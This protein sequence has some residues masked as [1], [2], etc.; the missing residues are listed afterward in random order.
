MS[1]ISNCVTSIR[2]RMSSLFSRSV[3]NR[4][5]PANESDVVKVYIN[6]ECIRV[7]AYVNFFI[8]CSCA[9]LINTHLVKPRLKEGPD[10][11]GSTCSPFDGVMG[12]RV[13]PPVFPGEGFDVSTQSHL[14]RAFG[15]NNI[16]VNWDYSPS[17]E[18]TAM[19]YPIFEYAL[20]LYLFFDFIQTY[21]YFKK[22]WV[23]KYYFRAVQC[24]IGFMILG[25]AWFR[26]I[27]V[28]IAY[29]N[30]QGHTAGFFC[31]QITL[32]MA[33]MVNAFFVIDSKIEYKFLW[34]RKGT[35][36]VAYVYLLL[37]L[38]IS[39]TKL[40]ATGHVVFNGTPASW[41]F[42]EVGGSV[43]GKHVDMVW[44]VCNAILPLIVSII[45]AFCEPSLQITVDVPISPR[46]DYENAEKEDFNDDEA[47][48]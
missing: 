4:R 6:V 12:D 25:C 13:E 17:R 47:D 3:T 40:I 26:M 16:C 34:G 32:V 24:L 35:L 28:M 8:M 48:S 7:I 11:E 29:E 46:S 27:F 33:A 15:F 14:Y 38:V 21:I 41:T 37:N 23:S 10:E 19:I 44:F 22:G 30:I 36:I 9:M 1:S 45:R 42:N 39:I 43:V 18:I 2:G 20:L 31:L 5:T